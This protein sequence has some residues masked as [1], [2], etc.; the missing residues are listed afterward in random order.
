MYRH[1]LGGDTACTP[2]QETYRTENACWSHGWDVVN[3]GHV[4]CYLEEEEEES[5]RPFL[6]RPVTYSASVTV[7]QGQ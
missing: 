5:L 7:F 2:S 1:C 4:Y 3:S 6:R